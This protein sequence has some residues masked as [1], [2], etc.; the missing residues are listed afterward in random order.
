MQI[1]EHWHFFVF[2]KVKVTTPVVHERFQTWFC[3]R[4]FEFF[5]CVMETTSC[6]TISIKFLSDLIQTQFLSPEDQRAISKLHSHNNINWYQ[7]CEAKMDP[8]I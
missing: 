7:T 5:K 2:G 8:L 6:Y 1:K 3:R 4:M